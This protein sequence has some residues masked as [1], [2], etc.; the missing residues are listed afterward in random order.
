MVR[1]EPD[2]HIQFEGFDLIVEAKLTEDSSCLEP[3]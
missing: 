3:E 1:V 2:L